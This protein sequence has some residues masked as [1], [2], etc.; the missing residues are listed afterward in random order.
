MKEGNKVQEPTEMECLSVAL[1]LLGLDFNPQ[2]AAL[3]YE[4]I[5]VFRK[6]KGK[7]DLLDISKVI[8]NNEREYG[9]RDIISVH[10]L[11]RKKEA[12][13]DSQEKEPTTP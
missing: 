13:D 5:N 3:I 11:H 9:E 10:V 4:T 8:A 6:K 12:K 1:R 2:M 7:T